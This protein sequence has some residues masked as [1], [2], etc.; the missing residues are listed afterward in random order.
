M[1]YLAKDC[2]GQVH[3]TVQ[4]RTPINTVIT[5]GSHKR[6]VNKK[7]FGYLAE[8]PV[9]KIYCAVE[10]IYFVL[11]PSD[12]MR[13][14]LLGK[15]ASH[16]HPSFSR[17]R[18]LCVWSSEMIPDMGKTNPYGCQPLFPPQILQFSRSESVILCENLPNN[19]PNYATVY[20]FC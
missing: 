15:A 1:V 17:T 20:L 5:S 19:R 11:L 18:N 16:G 8:Y 14:C 12:G 10:Y 6:R 13:L 9:V 4:W 2:I 7:L 3:D